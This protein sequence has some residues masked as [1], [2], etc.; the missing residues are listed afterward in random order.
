MS[1]HRRLTE[2]VSRT[3]ALA[4][5]AL[6]AAPAISSA[7]R[8]APSEP[9]QLYSFGDNL[10]GQL[11]RAVGAGTEDANSTPGLLNL[12]GAAGRVVALSAGAGHTLLVT[13]AGQLYSFGSNR[14]GQLGGEAGSAVDPNPVPTPVALPA[15]AAGGWVQAAA[16]ASF[17]LAVTAGGQLYS[18]GQNHSG[19]LGVA[20]NAGTETANSNPLA[21]TLPGASGPVVQIAAGEA[22]GLALTAGGQLYSFGSN[23]FGQLGRAAGAGTDAVN[24]QP[25]PVALPA[26]NGPIVQI[27]AGAAHG[28][29]LTASGQLYSFGENLYGQLGRSSGSGTM[30]AN[31]TPAPTAP[32]EASSPIVQVAAGRE[33]SLALGEDGQV[34]SFGQ[35]LYGQL[36][37]PQGSGTENANPVAAPAS[38]F[39]ATGRVVRIDSEAGSSFAL[40]AG[41][42]SF[43]FG[44]ND[45]GQLGTTVNAGSQSP[46]PPEQA[47][48]ASATTLDVLSGGPSAQ[49]TLALVADMAVLDGSLPAG[50]VAT[51]YDA[52][53]HVAGGA[54]GYNW[55]A[56]GLPAGLSIDPAS[57]RIAGTPAAAGVANVVLHVQDVFGIEATSA[58]IP[59]TVVARPALSTRAPIRSTLTELELLASLG[60]QL[61]MKG[62]VA[63]IASLRK[64]RRY[65]YAF[66]ALTAGTLSIDWYY[67]PP[68]AHLASAAPVL[69]A[70]GRQVFQ[71]AGT[72][73]ITVKLTKRGRG[74]LRRRRSI[75]LTAAGRFVARDVRLRAVSARRAFT[76]QR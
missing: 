33:D 63:H 59:L 69:V 58:T 4:A 30:A 41:G 31:A 5:C 55:S 17:S 62:R 6:L 22:F 14:Y 9:G 25:Q 70:G 13:S 61:G 10:S 35:N 39:A 15:S 72:K 47:E 44:E 7:A 48:F 40:D 71:S 49:H 34:Y 67:L 20:A 51:P 46:T 27:A 64:R 45:F 66:T 18:F 65:S 56:S 24:D 37:R 29:A 19:Q 60:K 11:G 73:L 16:G 38:Q 43:G 26:Q 52:E 8:A 42:Q 12:P 2:R 1:K 21:V 50:Q 28:L 23:Q 76:L 32:L 3:A 54:G 36:G 74:L 68:G 57:G 75:R 53:A